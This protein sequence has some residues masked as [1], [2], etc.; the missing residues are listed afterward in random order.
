MI[1]CFFTIIV[2]H[3]FNLRA[4]LTI[5]TDREITANI[6]RARGAAPARSSRSFGIIL[7]YFCRSFC[8]IIFFFW[9]FVLFIE[10]ILRLFLNLFHF[11]L[12]SL[13]VLGSSIAFNKFGVTVI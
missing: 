7:S 10:N 5:Y 1:F 3:F 9:H 8:L 4:T 11:D 13:F 2:A 12:T 6:A